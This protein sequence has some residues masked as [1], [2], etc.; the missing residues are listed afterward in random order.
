MHKHTDVRMDW[1]S[2]GGINIQLNYNGKTE[3]TECGLDK[4]KLH[5]R[6]N[7]SAAV[8]FFETKLI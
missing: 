4:N 2:Y 6:E 8:F 5:R 3:L 1:R 7:I